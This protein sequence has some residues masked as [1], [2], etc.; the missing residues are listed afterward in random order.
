MLKEIAVADAY[1]AGFEFSPMQIIKEKNDLKSYL[2]NNLYG[3]K[4]KYTDDAQMSIAIAELLIAG[5]DFDRTIVASKF[6]ECFKR[7]KRKGYA[8]GFYRLLCE[9]ETGEDLLKKINNNSSRNGAAMRSVPIGFLSDI[10]LLL[11]FAKGQASI[12]HNTEIAIKS[13]CAVALTAHFGL[14][15][16]G[17]LAELEGFLKKNK[18]S[19]WDLSWNGEVDVDAFQTVSAALTNLLKY[20]N[21]QD[22]LKGSVAL[23]GDTDTVAAISLGLASCFSEYK[24]DLPVELISGLDE[25]VYGMDYLVN[26]DNALMSK[27]IVNK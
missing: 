9:S 6:V 1:G 25:T 19:D 23:G 24:K 20:D 21:Y 14:Y 27:Y 7:D 3:F 18:C 15:N 16:L 11:K 12:T 8:K 10:P 4:A 17:S 2:P 22:L 26:L 13:S 5:C